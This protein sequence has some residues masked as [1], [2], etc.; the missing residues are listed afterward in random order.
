M[1]SKSFN[2]LVLVLFIATLSAINFLA[3]VTK[4]YAQETV[5]IEV[6]ENYKQEMNCLAENIYYESGFESYEGKL[7]VAQVTINRVNSGK[8]PTTVCGVVKQKNRI[9]GSWVCQFSWVCQ[10]VSHVVRNKYQWD[11]CVMVARKAITEANVHTYIAQTN[12]LYYH[13][14]QVRPGW[15]LIRVTQIGNHIFYR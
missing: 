7:A 8:F 12:S 13:N 6:S 9:N 11:E 4:S 2:I 15:K 3:P 1:Y 14:N 10:S 5:A